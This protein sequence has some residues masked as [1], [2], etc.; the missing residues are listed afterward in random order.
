LW[1]KQHFLKQSFCYFFLYFLNLLLG[2]V[3]L[4]WVDAGVTRVV[5]PIPLVV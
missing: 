2:E 3:I 5:F 1:T 4:R